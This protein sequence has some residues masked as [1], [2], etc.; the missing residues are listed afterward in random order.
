MY[1][2][3]RFA[4]VMAV[5]SFQKPLAIDDVHVSQHIC[6]PWDLDIWME[7][8]NGITLSLYDLG[9][10][11][12]AK[13]TGLIKALRENKWALAIAGTSIRYR[14]RVHMFQRYEMRTRVIGRDERFIYLQQSMWRNG[15]ATSSALYRSAL[16]DKNGI[17]PTQKL[18]DY[19]DRSD[20]NPTLPDWVQ[21]WI[22]AEG[23]RIWPPEY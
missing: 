16:T 13:R 5:A 22:E 8:N 17:V 7:M 14:R 4:K 1:P 2:F 20:W 21:N 12:F 9:R 10:L 11:P 19:Y 15:E 3:I 23:T 6:W 18:A